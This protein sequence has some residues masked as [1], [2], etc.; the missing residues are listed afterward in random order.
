[1][2]KITTQNR[3]KAASVGMPIVAEGTGV[4]VSTDF[5]GIYRSE[6]TIPSTVF[7]VA[8]ASL[9][10]GLKLCTLPV[11]NIIVHHGSVRLTY[12]SS[13]ANTV[14]AVIGVG[15]VIASGPVADLNG[16]GTFEDCIDGFTATAFNGTTPVTYTSAKAG[17]V[18]QKD[19]TSTAKSLYLNIAGGFGAI[20]GN[21]TYSG[22]VTVY[23][24]VAHAS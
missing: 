3:I 17:E 10:F 5:T 22:K 4:T 20:T 13:V 6:F 21:L 18:D 14:Q 19:G 16:T 11:G 12:V 24:S 8:A 7:A 23:W 1:M 2:G 15:T 9:G